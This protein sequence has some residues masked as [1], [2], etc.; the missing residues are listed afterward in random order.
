M[1]TTVTGFL[2]KFQNLTTFF[3]CP[4]QQLQASCRFDLHEMIRAV[5][6]S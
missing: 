2:N 1:A 4:K 6:F 5:G 3:L